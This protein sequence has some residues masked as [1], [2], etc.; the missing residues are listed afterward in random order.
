MSVHND[1]D[2]IEDD[3]RLRRDGP[4]VKQLRKRS[5]TGMYVAVAFVLIV[6]ILIFVF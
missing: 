4:G 1:P 5:R 3:G 6:A 2:V